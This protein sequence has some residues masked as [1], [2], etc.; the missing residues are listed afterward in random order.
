MLQVTPARWLYSARNKTASRLN[1]FPRDL[2]EVTQA[3][4]AHIA[5]FLSYTIFFIQMENVGN[6]STSLRTGVDLKYEKLIL[7]RTGEVR[8]F[9]KIEH[10][11]T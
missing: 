6:V 7:V 10:S 9:S 1:M 8:L 4:V 11:Q 2:A 3:S 5:A